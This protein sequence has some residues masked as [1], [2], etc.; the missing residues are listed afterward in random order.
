MDDGHHILYDT[1]RDNI[2]LMSNS[3]LVLPR[4]DGSAESG[5]YGGVRGTFITLV[6]LSGGFHIDDN[7]KDGSMN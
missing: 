7:T 6:F 3:S 2:R 4:G 5:V 1:R